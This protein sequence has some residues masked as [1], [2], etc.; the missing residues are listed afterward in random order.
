MTSVAWL[1]QLTEGFR[2]CDT[3]EPSCAGVNETC[4]RGYY[5]INP[6]GTRQGNHAICGDVVTELPLLPETYVLCGHEAF[7]TP[8][9]RA[10]LAAEAAAEAAE[11]GGATDGP[12][13]R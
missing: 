4:R 7:L 3:E 9:Q 5:F 6:F 12:E 1:L 2:S 8:E 13:T 10:I 11:G